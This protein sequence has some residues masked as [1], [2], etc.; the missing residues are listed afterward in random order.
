MRE[1]FFEVFQ[2]G[3]QN[4]FDAEH[5]GAENI[6][7]VFDAPVDF[8]ESDIN[9]SVDLAEPDFDIPRNIVQ[10]LVVDKY[11]GEHGKRGESGCGKRSHQLVGNGHKLFLF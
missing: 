8:G 10:P 4:L 1:G 6:L 3:V 2:A 11:A 5:F 7:G 9:V